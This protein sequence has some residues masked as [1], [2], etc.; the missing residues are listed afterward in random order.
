MIF[1]MASIYILPLLIG[2]D[3]IWLSVLMAEAL[4]AVMAFGL[5]GTDGKKYFSR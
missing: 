3:G 4:S 5:L 1:Q 2:S